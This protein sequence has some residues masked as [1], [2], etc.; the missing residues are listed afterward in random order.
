MGS[1]NP[2]PFSTH[3]T[4]SSATLATTTTTTTQTLTNNTPQAGTTTPQQPPHEPHQYIYVS[5]RTTPNP[6][7]QPKQKSRLSRFLSKFESSAVRQANAARESKRLEA[8]RTGVHTLA[9]TGTP[10]NAAQI[11]GGIPMP[12]GRRWYQH[13]RTLTLGGRWS[14]NLVVM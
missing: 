4:T 13:K 14:S 3:S 2:H 12:S 10:G 5:K 9:V 6:D 7:A 1:S 8:E 11:H